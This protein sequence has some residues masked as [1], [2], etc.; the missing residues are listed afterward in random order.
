MKTTLWFI[1]FIFSSFDAFAVGLDCGGSYFKLEGQPS[2]HKA[3]Y[4]SAGHC[5]QVTDEG[6]YYYDPDPNAVGNI[7][8]TMTKLDVSINRSAK[9]I[10]EIEAEGKTVY[11]LSQ[12][13]MGLGES[14]YFSNQTCLLQDIV[15]S[16]REGQWTWFGSYKYDPS[17]ER[18]HGMSGMPLISTVSNQI[19]GVHN[20]GH[21]GEEDC[22]ENNPCEVDESG[23]VR[24]FPGNGYGQPTHSL[25]QCFND[26][27]EFDL[28]LETCEL[29]GSDD[30]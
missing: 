21:D 8:S 6:K 7:Y 20:T 4:I 22:I 29:T 15:H 5:F 9:T 18:E 3:M 23:N 11:V 16:L 24:G 14:F 10:A 19:V 2:N 26:K 25:Y 1:L 28:G 17:C 13:P 30:Y 12:K 27:Y